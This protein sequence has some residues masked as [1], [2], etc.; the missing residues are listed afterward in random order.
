MG[1]GTHARTRTCALRCPCFPLLG[2]QAAAHD[3]GAGGGIRP[4]SSWRGW[5]YIHKVGGG[6]EREGGWGRAQRIAWYWPGMRV[7]GISSTRAGSCMCVPC[8]CQCRVAVTPP[9]S[10]SLATTKGQFPIPRVA[11]ML[12]T[13][14]HAHISAKACLA[15]CKLPCSWSGAHAAARHAPALVTH[16][17]QQLPWSGLRARVRHGGDPLKAWPGE[18]TQEPCSH[19]GGGVKKTLSCD[20]NNCD[21]RGRQ[22]NAA[23]GDEPRAICC[24]WQP[25]VHGLVATSSDASGASLAWTCE[26]C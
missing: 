7:R 12:G 17:P 20:E 9:R 1:M 13:D 24:S 15:C 16:P 11:S 19:E 6:R 18:Q 8:Q 22:N 21:D 4:P 3:K 2:E 23:C 14:E 10:L 25:V 5:V 26:P